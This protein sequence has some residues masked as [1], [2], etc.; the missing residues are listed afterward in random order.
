MDR[1]RAR[2][3]RQMVLREWTYSLGWAAAG[4]QASMRGN[5]LPHGATRNGRSTMGSGAHAA[6]PFGI[7]RVACTCLQ[8]AAGPTYPLTCPYPA[9]SPLTAM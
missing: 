3:G 5:A 9:C 6:K 8:H 7:Q 4:Q 2:A 1:G